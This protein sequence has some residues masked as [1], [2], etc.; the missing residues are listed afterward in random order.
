MGQPLHPN[1]RPGCWGGAPP[2]R[3][4]SGPGCP[5]G[6]AVEGRDGSE[7]GTERAAATWPGPRGSWGGKAGEGHAGSR[8][9]SVVDVLVLVARPQCSWSDQHRH[10]L[11]ARSRRGAATVSLGSAYVRPGGRVPGWGMGSLWLWDHSPSAWPCASFLKGLETLLVFRRPWLWALPRSVSSSHAAPRL[12]RD[13][14][15][16]RVSTGRSVSPGLQEHIPDG[17]VAFV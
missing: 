17:S 9:R 4:G 16:V 8:L 1:R 5:A 7:P 13:V 14:Y 12:G 2:A 3:R 15:S 10:F 11:K 6:H